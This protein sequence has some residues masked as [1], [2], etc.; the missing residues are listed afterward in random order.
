MQQS[1]GIDTQSAGFDKRMHIWLRGFEDVVIEHKS[2][3]P[4][5]GKASRESERTYRIFGCT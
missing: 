1:I 2:D 4:I 3:S 5:P